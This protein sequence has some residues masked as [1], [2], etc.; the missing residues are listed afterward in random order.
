[1]REMNIRI[2]RVFRMGQ[3][4][5][6]ERVKEYGLSSGLFNYLIELAEQDGLSM[7][8]LSKAVGVDNG[9]TTRMVKR[10]EELGHVYK[11]PNPLDSRSSQVFLTDKGCEISQVI[12]N[13]FIEWKQIIVKDVTKEEI[14][15]VNSVF[16][17]FYENAY[18]AQYFKRMTSGKTLKV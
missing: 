12:N 14:L 16:N 9:F 2:S 6:N 13:I 10:L 11:K 15:S 1:L 7:Q 18:N 8:E 5:M 17:K 3:A 4:Y